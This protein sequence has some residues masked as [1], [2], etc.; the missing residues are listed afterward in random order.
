MERDKR[1][2]SAAKD[3]IKTMVDKIQALIDDE[4]KKTE[5]ET[6]IKTIEIKMSSIKSLDDSILNEVPDE[7]MK[8]E[9]ELAN[10]FEVEIVTHLDKFKEK[11]SKYKFSSNTTVFKG[12]I[13]ESFDSKSGVK[14]PKIFIKKFSGDPLQWQQFEATFDAT[15]TKNERI[16]DIEKFTYLRGY[17]CGEA[18]KCIEGITLIGHNFDRAMALLRERYGN[19]QLIISSHMDSLLKLEK[20]S[21]S[22]SSIKELRNLY[23]KIESHLRSLATLG[24]KSEHYSPM[25]IPIIVNKL[26]NEIRLEISRRLGTN[27]WRINHFM[28]TLKIEITARENCD[29]VNSLTRGDKEYT[30]D[31]G[32]RDRRITTQAL[33]ANDR[34]LKC[35]FCGENHYNDK[36]TVVTDIDSRKKIVF[37][38]KLCFKCLASSHLKKDCRSRRNCYSCK[39]IHHHTA[40][41]DR[42]K[43][44]YRSDNNEVIPEKT[45]VNHA[46]TKVSVLLQT[47]EAEV[48]DIEEK[49]NKRI[50]I[51]LDPGSQKTYVLQRTADALNLKPVCEEQMI[52]KTFGSTSDKPMKVKEYELVVKSKTGMNLY[53]KAYGVPT[54]C[55]ALNGQEVKLAADKF[56]FLK[57]SLVCNPVA[58]NNNEI[59]LLIGSDFYW[60]IINNEIK[61]CSEEGL[62]AIS[63]QLGPVS[64]PTSPTSAVN[65]T[66]VMN[67]GVDLMNDSRLN[68]SVEKFWNLD[69]VGIVENEESVYDKFVEDITVKNNRFEV[70]LPFK[71]GH[72]LIEDNFMLSLN[73]LK[74]LTKKLRKSPDVL[75]T[76]DD[77]I[78]AQLELGIIE[79]AKEPAAIG[80]VTY[81]LSGA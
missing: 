44:K 58:G 24:V 3:I 66:H 35:C 72:P 67:I 75:K 5:I 62:V 7:G 30:N 25:F 39:S 77:V 29:Y 38:K 40:I 16:S 19:P 55:S 73:R 57:E 23:D 45:H 18:E 76:Y 33:L 31:Y 65:Y 70:R 53:V 52:I 51:L 15:I 21:G 9:M 13:S 10:E 50:R 28:D 6:L 32:R 61:R 59:D 2:R 1:K 8:E 27:N 74:S 48:C 47:A 37:D 12:S 80:E 41:C 26:P 42:I 22:R 34:E 20:V 69:S 68:E 14:L 71:E 11:L 46:S 78:R 79:E 43:M 49:R 54:I 64:T 63:S 56:P 17:V 36:C 81:L 60:I 4:Q